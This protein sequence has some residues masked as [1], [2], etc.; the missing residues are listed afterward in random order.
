MNSITLSVRKIAIVLVIAF[1]LGGLS[2]WLWIA[3]LSAPPQNA[4][5]ERE[6]LEAHGSD[7]H[8]EH[9]RQDK[10]EEGKLTLS[11]EAQREAGI[12]ITE[13]LGGALEQTLNLP[14]EIMLNADRVVHIVPRVGGIVQRVNKTLGDEVKPGEIMAVLESREL[15]ETKAAYLAAKQ[16]LALA[17]ATLASAEELRAKRILPGLEYLGTKRDFDNAAIELRTVTQKLHALGL[18]ETEIT[19]ITQNQDKGVAFAVYELRAPAAGTVIEK[20]ITLGE[21]VENNSDVFIIADLSAVWANVTVYAQD[22]PRLSVGQAVHITAEG[23]PTEATGKI[24]YISPVVAEATRTA[25]A[26]VLVP[27]PNERWK[28]GTF[29][30]ALIVLATEPVRTLIPNDAIQTVDNKPVVFVPEDDGFA[31]RPVTV[32]RANSTHSQILAGLEPRDRYVSTGAFVL[33]AELGKGEGG[34]DH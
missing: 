13:A 34:H 14:G 7:A 9:E 31:P 16:R 28:P 24:S 20:H 22:T 10:H 1:L 6:K 11:P 3:R 26:R 27:N 30:T 25:T 5:A 19:A 18:T 8:D 33:K 12:T 2:A 29:I 4:H 21:V 32:G 23:F 17:K 15:A